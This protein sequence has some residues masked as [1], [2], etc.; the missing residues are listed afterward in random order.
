MNKCHIIGRMT[1]D[2]EVRY[3]QGGTAVA[4]FTLAVDRRVAKDKPKEAD[5]IPCVVWGKMADGVVKN[6]CHKGKQVAVEGRIQVRSYD[7]KDGTK[8]YVTEVIVN[9]LE[10]LGKGDGSSKQGGGYQPLDD[11]SIPF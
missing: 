3:T 2:P 8:R 9:D 4:T 1:K 5:F 11:E 10:L 6:Y 7:A